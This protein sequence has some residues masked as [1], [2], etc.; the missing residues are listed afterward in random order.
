MAFAQKQ[1]KDS[2]T[3]VTIPPVSF[4]LNGNGVITIPKEIL[5][6]AREEYSKT[7]NFQNAFID[8]L[9][10]CKDIPSHAVEKLYYLFQDKVMF[11]STR[12][13]PFEKMG[14]QTK[15]NLPIKYD[16]DTSISSVEGVLQYIVARS[17][18]KSL[19]I[20]EYG[21]EY[22]EGSKGIPIPIIGKFSKNEFENALEEFSREIEESKISDSRKMVYYNLLALAKREKSW[23]LYR[24][25]RDVFELCR[26]NPD[27]IEEQKFYA[28]TDKITSF[29]APQTGHI[30]RTYS[31]G[32]APSISPDLNPQLGVGAGVKEQTA[33]G[34][35]PL[36]SAGPVVLISSKPDVGV[37]LTLSNIISGTLFLGNQQ[38]FGLATLQVLR[39]SGK[40]D[41][42][43]GFG[44]IGSTEGIFQVPLS[45]LRQYPWLL[46][47]PAAMNLVS[48]SFE[49]AGRADQSTDSVLGSSLLAF[50]AYPAPIYTIMRIVDLFDY[51]VPDK[52]GKERIWYENHE[53]LARALF[54]L[55]AGETNT[56]LTVLDGVL[57][58]SKGATRGF[59]LAREDEGI[60]Q[61]TSHM[62]K[63]EVL[64]PKKAIEQRITG[65]TD[66]LEKILEK[67]ITRA[68]VFDFLES[69]TYLISKYNE[70]ILGNSPVNPLYLSSEADLYR[71][72]ETT[73]KASISFAGFA[74]NNENAKWVLENLQQDLFLLNLA[75]PNYTFYNPS[76]KINMAFNSIFNA[77]KKEAKMEIEKWKKERD[78]HIRVYGNS[79][80]FKI[81]RPEKDIEMQLDLG[82]ISALS[83]LMKISLSKINTVLSEQ[84][85]PLFFLKEKI[86]YHLKQ[87]GVLM[88]ERTYNDFLKKFM[89]FQALEETLSNSDL[90]QMVSTL[91]ML[92]GKIP[93]TEY[94]EMEDL[95][96]VWMAK[97]SKIKSWL[98]TRPITSNFRGVGSSSQAFTPKKE[99]DDIFEIIEKKERSQYKTKNSICEKY[100]DLIK[101]LYKFELSSLEKT[102]QSHPAIVSDAESFAD[103]VLTLLESKVKIKYNDSEPELELT[104]FE[105]AEELEGVGK[106]IS[107]KYSRMKNNAYSIERYQEML[108]P[109]KGNKSRLEEK[110]K[111]LEIENEK[112]SSEIKNLEDK[113]NLLLRTML[114]SFELPITGFKFQTD[115]L[116]MNI[117]GLKVVFRNDRKMIK[118]LEKLEAR[119]KELKSSYNSIYESFYKYTEDEKALKEQLEVYKEASHL[120]NQT[121]RGVKPIRTQK[122]GS[123]EAI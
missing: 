69:Y 104:P 12:L 13:S 36:Y 62:R 40:Y 16:I 77:R 24:T 110:V 96:R 44:K 63:G 65:H 42:M 47:I 92:K 43:I 83:G 108:S 106:L 3:Q 34:E 50:M 25:G 109:E 117:N 87:K 116:L 52:P 45:V 80:N 88:S 86:A 4:D 122:R 54:F 70:Y 57:A 14:F 79:R 95:V 76:I 51:I 114:F 115:E 97:N 53:L 2:N 61:E 17:Y 28:L 29:I 71:F 9:K 82:K 73:T 90:F 123:A 68:N 75:V 27:K 22:S 39:H 32:I 93:E 64:S 58:S 103:R 99:L 31:V 30:L 5:I 72:V 102:R 8:F 67:G 121:L 111:N 33:F 15:T 19:T 38:S 81:P 94:S 119:L 26:D 98:K 85:D 107:L 35:K 91:L 60:I 49:I 11:Y 6:K 101:F 100:T 84:C 59:A 1:E 48:G 78:E 7:G 120:Y 105:I 18:G 74:N 37:N 23:A 112:I 55:R 41:L 20:T 46:A 113:R 66:K 10:K 56:A 118:E 21:Q 89:N